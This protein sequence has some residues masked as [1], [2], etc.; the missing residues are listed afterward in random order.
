MQ[1]RTNIYNQLF[2]SPKIKFN[3]DNFR[4][5]LLASNSLKIDGVERDDKG[6]YQ[7]LVSNAKGSVQ[8]A[9]ELKLG[10]KFT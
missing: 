4:F 7:C 10:G 8:A 2:L 5:T 6:I 3:Y 9:G 1:I